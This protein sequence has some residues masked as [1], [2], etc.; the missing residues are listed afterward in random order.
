MT[1]R[2]S[3]FVLLSLTLILS[4]VALLTTASSYKAALMVTGEVGG[5]PIYE[6]MVSGAKDA[7]EAKDFELKIVEGGYN[8]ANWKP[9]LINLA[10]TGQYDLIITFTQGMTKAVPEVARQFP[11]QNLALIDGVVE[12]PPPNVFSL[13]FKNEEMTYLAGYFAGL[14]TQSN[15]KRANDGLKIGLL[16]GDTYPAMTEKM[17]PAYKAGA[18]KV[19]SNIKMIFSSAGTWNDPNKGRLL[20]KSQFRQGVDIILTIAGGTGVGA[21]EAAKNLEGYTIGVD[22][23]TID[24]APNT[25]LACTLK[26]ADKAIKDVLMRDFEGKLPYGTS[27]RWGVQKGVISFTFE[28]PTYIENVPE[29]IRVKV[30]QVYNQLAEGEIQPLK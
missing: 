27:E 17:K 26:H 6:L 2:K 4:A 15:L 24:L 11:N 21:I 7:A 13:G 1:M 18:Q 22:S 8:P 3:L 9:N 16:A 19:N 12:D 28:D 29:D 20:A 23:N 5:N 14:V 25:I 10:A 30:K